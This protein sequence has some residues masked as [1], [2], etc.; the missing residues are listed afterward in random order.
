MGKPLP[1]RDHK[2]SKDEAKAK[3]KK[4]KEK[5]PKK[6][7]R[8]PT[9]AYHAEAYRRILDQPGCVGIRTY[10]GEDEDGTLTTILVGVDAD[11]NDMVEG[12]LMQNPF[13]CPPECSDGNE[14]NQG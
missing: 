7:D 9:V 6:E 1:P 3:T 10:P 11:G 8:F 12:A 2:I 13:F 4:Y 5:K 14:L